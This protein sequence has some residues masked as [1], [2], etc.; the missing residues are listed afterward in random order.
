MRK[1]DGAYRAGRKILVGC[2]KRGERYL[3]SH[4]RKTKWGLDLDTTLPQ[5]KGKAAKQQQTERE[6]KGKGLNRGERGVAGT[7]RVG[8]E[9]PN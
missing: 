5:G 1:D 7:G 4:S 8:E 3:Q 6:Q 9:G 2:P